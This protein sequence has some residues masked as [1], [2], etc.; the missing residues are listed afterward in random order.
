V[1]RPVAAKRAARELRRGLGDAVLAE[2]RWAFRPPRAWLSGVAVNLVLSLA[3]LVVQPVAHEGG[4]DWVVLV[5]SYFSSFI[6]ADVTT[7]NMLGVD[8]IRVAKGIRDGASVKRLLLVKN[9]ALAAIVGL[10]TMALAITLTLLM[11]TPGRLLMTVPDVAVPIVCW[12]GLGNLISV[13]MP[14]PYQP[15]I[16]RWRQ[17]RQVRRTIGWL[18]H[19]LLPYALYYVADPVYG[20]PRVIVWTVLPA[21][22]GGTL[23]PGAGYSLIHVGFAAAVWL[24]MWVM[25]DLAVRLRPVPSWTDSDL[26]SAQTR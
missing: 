11:E 3:W 21:V 25:A 22:L 14:V 1:N 12:L 10:P 16:R 13:L 9:L 24:T 23:G 5:A 6:L 20:L 4:R 15:L 18:G 8:H 17:R 19:L 7:T 2:I 26:P